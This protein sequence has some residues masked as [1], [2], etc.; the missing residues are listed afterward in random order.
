MNAVP[1]GLV[2]V[3]AGVIRSMLNVLKAIEEQ[4]A[5]EAA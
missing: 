4:K 3:M 2:T 5:G 1:R